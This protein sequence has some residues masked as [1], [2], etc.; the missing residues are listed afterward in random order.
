VLSRLPADTSTERFGAKRRLPRLVT[1]TCT[2][3]RAR[4]RLLPDG[5]DAGCRIAE[6][7][8]TCTS[9]A[10]FSGAVV[11]VR[12]SSSAGVVL[13]DCSSG[14]MPNTRRCRRRSP[15]EVAGCAPRDSFLSVHGT[16]T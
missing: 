7:T 9:F 10:G 8:R 16:V 1:R 4:L 14:V 6:M 3:S 12:V 2:L 15:S 11:V 13:V 5:E